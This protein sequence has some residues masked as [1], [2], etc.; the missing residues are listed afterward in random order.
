MKVIR[1][2]L[3]QHF[4]ISLLEDYKTNLIYLIWPWNKKTH[5]HSF[6]SGKMHQ[7]NENVNKYKRQT[8]QLVLGFK[9]YSFFFVKLLCLYQDLQQSEPCVIMFNVKL[10]VSQCPGQ[11]APHFSFSFN[12]RKYYQ[13]QGLH[14]HD[15]YH[16]KLRYIESSV[17][18]MVFN[19]STAHAVLWNR[20]KK[21]NSNVCSNMLKILIILF[22]CIFT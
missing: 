1:E 2:S 3:K 12:T 16:G 15:S 11:Q 7:I 10:D 6:M 9:L 8:T 14:A 21:I 20:L 19:I 18:V 22:I 5:F 4:C 17:T 13:D